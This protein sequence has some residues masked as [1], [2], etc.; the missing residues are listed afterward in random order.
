MCHMKTFLLPA[1][2][3]HKSQISTFTWEFPQ[4]YLYKVSLVNPT[5]NY[6]NHNI[7]CP[8]LAWHSMVWSNCWY[9]TLPRFTRRMFAQMPLCFCLAPLCWYL[10]ANQR[11][12]VVSHWQTWRNR[13]SGGWGAI[14]RYTVGTLVTACSVMAAQIKGGATDKHQVLLPFSASVILSRQ[15][16]K[17]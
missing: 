5:F 9:E 10:S 17:Q 4:A 6:T 7:C 1:Q 3:F 2:N 13:L 11:N 16:S 8:K 14:N 15:N 12:L